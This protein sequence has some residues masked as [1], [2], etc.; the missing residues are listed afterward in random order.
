MLLVSLLKHQHKVFILIFHSK[1]NRIIEEGCWS[2]EGPDWQLQGLSNTGFYYK[3]TKDSSRIYMWQK[4][5]LKYCNH[6]CKWGQTSDNTSRKCR[7]ELIHCG[8]NWII[9]I[10]NCIILLLFYFGLL[11]KSTTLQLNTYLN[12][13][14]CK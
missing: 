4:K 2:R 12:T 11:L 10:Y 1:L 7:R 13:I 6:S 9:A 3:R 8:F 5:P 14:F